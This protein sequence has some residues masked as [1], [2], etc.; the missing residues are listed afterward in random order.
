MSAV[1]QQWRSF[2]EHA[3]CTVFQKFDWLF[4]WHSHVGQRRNISPVIVVGLDAEGQFLMIMPLA[5]EN[6]GG[7]R[8]LLWL[9]SD[10][11]DYN[12]PLLTKNFDRYLGPE[13]FEVLWHEI[14]R[15]IRADPRLR[16]DLVDIDKL[17]EVVGSQKNPFLQ[18]SVLPTNYSAH[19]ATLGKDWEKFY[20]SRISS[21]S[22]K[23]D[24]R[25]F[26][27]LA[28]RGQI[29]FVTVQDRDDIE[30]TMNTL[31]R[32]KRESYAR[33]GVKDI[34]ART[35]Y[36]EFYYAIATS[37][38]LLDVVHLSRLDVGAIPAATGLGLK[39]KTCYY[40][41]LSSY[42]DSELAKFSPGRA[43]IHEIFRYA[44]DRKVDKFDFTIGDEPYKRDWCDI[45][46]RLFDYL[47]AATIKGHIIVVLRTA[48][49]RADLFVCQRP[50]LRRPFSKARRFAK[51]ISR[52]CATL[53]AARTG[54]A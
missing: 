8:R 20:L 4:Q 13:Q 47:E 10:L 52:R 23:A 1:E 24:R 9:G 14:I 30:R 12:A 3:D 43:H 46:L 31:I 22:R 39:F 5:I 32:Q 7:I 38:R 49:R 44:I 36:P 2:E 16:F 48:I 34:F 18:L 53:I 29:H 37:P 15:V 51:V 6:R 40:L 35:G 26:K 54:S 27:N 50:L 42:E 17:P 41:V 45:E 21:T 25:K 19:V 11:C 28:E 33:M